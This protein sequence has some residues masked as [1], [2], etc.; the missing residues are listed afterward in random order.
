MIEKYVTLFQNIEAWSDYRR[1][2]IPAL[3]PD[4]LPSVNPQFRH[5][6]P[7]RLFYSGSEMNVN[8]HIPDPGTQVATNGFRNPNDTADCP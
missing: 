6:I 8:S 4:T 5:K 7:G 2:C 3:T 1:M